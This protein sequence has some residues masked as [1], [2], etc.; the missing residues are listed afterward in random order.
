MASGAETSGDRQLIEAVADARARLR[1]IAGRELLRRRAAWVLGAGAALGA[2]RPILLRLHEDAPRWI[3]VERAAG[4]VAAGSALA[5]LFVVV[6]GRSRRGPSELGA[7]RAV[8]QALG[9]PEVVASGLAFGRA[10]NDEPFAL[11]ARRRAH[12]AIASLRVAPMFPLPSLVPTWRSA[13]RFAA[14]ALL[15][16]LVGSYD[17]GLLQALLA[18]PTASERAAAAELEQVVTELTSQLDA[19]KKDVGREHSTTRDKTDDRGGQRGPSLSEMAREAARAAKRGDRKG[20][21]EKLD[22]MRTRGADEAARAGEIGATLRKLAEALGSEPTK[23]G[24]SD[25]A[26]ANQGAA[27]ASESMRL[28][29]KKMRS[30]EAANG[31]EQ[32]ADK[33]T[34]E[35]LERAGDEARRAAASGKNPDASEAARALSRAAEAL[36]KG[37]REAAAREL[38]QAA[39]R[40]ASMEE[41]RSAMAAEAMAVAEMLERSGALERAIQMAL[42][43]REGSGKG[44]GKGNGKGDDGLALGDERGSG[45]KGDKSG[46]GR[47]GEGSA[48]AALRAAIMARLAAMGATDPDGDPGTGS[49][50]HI[51]DRKRARREALVASGSLQ[52]PSQVN[53]GERAIQ[54]I[55]GLGK[56]TEPPASYREVFPAYDAAAEEGMAD[57]RIP[58]ATRGAVRRYFRS[59]RPEP[60]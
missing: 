41:Q 21:L 60:R 7:A 48:G 12:A 49:G 35:R 16:V 57:E 31:S 13:G 15:A 5:A 58:A 8:D 17:R 22:G 53:E 6:W 11:L 47:Q 10:G 9:L 33:R 54:A 59:I 45:D 19:T 50:P 29:A 36:K 40:A 30:G 25:G 2:C 18:P 38:E 56:G 34:L 1:R 55:K 27:S 46:Q 20:A 44:S 51:P 26:R 32:D 4:L 43:G 23:T 37:D 52:A 14:C 3:A 42:L 28:L 39:D 24:A